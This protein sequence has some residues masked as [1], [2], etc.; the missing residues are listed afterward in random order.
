MSLRSD[1]W[2]RGDDEVAL[3]SRVALRMGGAAVD[4]SGGRPIIGIA[5]SSS[6][7]NPC[8]QPLDELVAPLKDGVAR[9]GGV[10]V[11]FPM[12]SLG[13]DL[14]KPSSM[15]Y[16]NLVAM[17]LEESLRS[18][19]LDAVVVLAACDKSVPGALMGAF[20]T[21]L[22][23]LLVVS[24]PRPVALFEGRRIGTGTDLWRLWDQ[25][26]AG[27][28]TDEQWSELERA[29]TLGK[30]TCNTMGTAST[31]GALAEALGLAWPGSTT[32]PA[33]DPRHIDNARLV[34]ERIVELARSHRPATSQVTPEAL[35][36]ALVVLAAIGGST[37]AV[38]H[39]TAMARRLGHDLS[40]E[41]I[42]RVGRTTPVI[43]D[44]E[45][46]GAALL[47]DLDAAGGF[48]SVFRALDTR[49]AGDAELADG[50]QMKQVQLDAPAPGAVI[51]RPEDP[52]DADGAFRVVRGNLAPNGAL[53]KRSAA[54]R[55]LL[56]HRGPA[57]VIGD[58]DDLER[59]TGPG[60]TCPDNAVLVFAGIGPV[61]GPGM[62]EWGM[63][64]IPEPLL[65]RGVTDMVRVTDSRMSGTS[66]GTVYLHV[67]PEGA[68][69]GAIGL[70]R[71]GDMI[72]VDADAGVIELEVDEEELSRRRQR[73]T[74]PDRDARGYVELY[75]R[76]VTQA[77]DGCDFDF[78]VQPSGEPPQLSEPVVGRS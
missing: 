42:D 30:G 17:E 69:G 44:V 70:V 38:I 28:L 20:S 56:V 13:E 34:G 52:V 74:R 66:F 73:A 61:G 55:E 18:Q 32:L 4:A 53:I 63:I 50:R 24:G 37:N 65:E 7:L 12:M 16:R 67:S 29:L 46:S 57:Y 5:N 75:R 26:R 36:N 15:L 60:T 21:N 27:E 10:A 45:P 11:E 1:R 22:P 2:V 49:L 47:E 78:L 31:M 35:E 33:G 40:L 54:T 43:V 6:D 8:N 9:A 51:H 14:M 72:R 71:D 59:R 39:L 25:R 68:A 64:P 48:P 58:V 62:P 77:P 76:H 3:D 23:T 19:P 41:D